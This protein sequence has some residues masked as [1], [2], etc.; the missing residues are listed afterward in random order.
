MELKVY[1]VEERGEKTKCLNLVRTQFSVF[2]FDG[3]SL[4]K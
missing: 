3:A 1:Q 4:I 2:G